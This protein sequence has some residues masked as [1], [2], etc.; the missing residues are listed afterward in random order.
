MQDGLTAHS[1]AKI[2]TPPPPCPE[3]QHPMVLDRILNAIGERPQLGA[4]FCEPCQ[5][6]ETVVLG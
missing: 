3:C 2:A 5:F 6:A 1:T 4:Y